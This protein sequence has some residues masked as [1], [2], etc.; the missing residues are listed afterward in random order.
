MIG[1]DMHLHSVLKVD[2]GTSVWHA[3]RYRRRLLP[4]LHAHRKLCACICVVP[5]PS[6]KAPWEQSIWTLNQRQAKVITWLLVGCS[7]RAHVGLRGLYHGWLRYIK[8][9]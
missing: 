3:L 6:R 7:G 1:L 9:A 8:A 4:V 5:S 2:L